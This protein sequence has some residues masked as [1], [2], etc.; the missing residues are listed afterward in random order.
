M[1]GRKARLLDRDAIADLVCHA[2][3]LESRKAQ[4]PM[5]TEVGQDSWVRM[6]THA[7]HVVEGGERERGIRADGADNTHTV[8]MD[9]K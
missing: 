3:L 6:R 5:Q 2:T 8:A 1:L 9:E 4:K 7:H